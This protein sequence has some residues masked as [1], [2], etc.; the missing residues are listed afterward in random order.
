MLSI[1]F[2]QALNHIMRGTL[3]KTMLRIG[4]PIKIIKFVQMTMDNTSVKV[5]I[6]NKLS[7][8]YQINARVKQG[9]GPSRTLFNNALPASLI[10]QIRKKHFS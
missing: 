8:L 7:E 2:K 5:K 1:G 4:I 3:Y 9:N 10:K 6:G